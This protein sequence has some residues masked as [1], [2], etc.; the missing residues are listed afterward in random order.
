M[1]AFILLGEIVMPFFLAWN[2]TIRGLIVNSVTKEYKEW[3]Y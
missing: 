1:A 2:R 3:N